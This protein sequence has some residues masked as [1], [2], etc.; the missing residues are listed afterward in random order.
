MSVAT[1]ITEFLKKLAEVLKRPLTSTEKKAITDS[2][3]T[4]KVPVGY[5]I[6]PNQTPL[7][8]ISFSEAHSRGWKSVAIRVTNDGTNG[9]AVEKLDKVHKTLEAAKIQ[10]ALAWVWMNENSQFTRTK[11]VAQSKFDG[12]L[13]DVETYQ[14]T[15]VIPYIQQLI[16]DAGN[17]EVILCTKPDGWDGQQSYDKLM[18]LD[19][20]A[21][22]APMSYIGDY[23]KSLTEL[24]DYF[25]ALNK[26]YPGRVIACLETY[27]SDSNTVPKTVTEIQAEIDMVKPHVKGILLFRYGYGSYMT[28]DVAKN[29]TPPTNNTKPETQLQAEKSLGITFQTFTEF[30]NHIK[31]TKKYLYYLDDQF[32]WNQELSKGFNYL[33]CVDITQAG[34][35]LAK[36]MGYTATPYGIYCPGYGVN[37]AIFMI[38]GKEFTLETWID[39][40]AATSENYNIGSHWC[41]GALTKAPGWIPG[42]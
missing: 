15:K 19:K 13:V 8:K 21:L 4:D 18:A 36:A 27:K 25:K 14:M 42:E 40:A 33:N 28:K 1:V 9:L 7:D 17:K 29:T 31:K 35:K 32:T 37:H 11:E 5:F 3:P 34:I 41:D 26:K 30:Y 38:K 12:L 2:V 10:E 22:I 23:N 20:R 24:R 6:D 39:L 16:K